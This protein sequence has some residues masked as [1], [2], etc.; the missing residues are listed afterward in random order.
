VLTWPVLVGLVGLFVALRAAP[1]V[2][3]LVVTVAGM[4]LL[5][6]V[7]AVLIL[8]YST[9]LSGVGFL[10]SVLAAAGAWRLSWG[11]KRTATPAQRRRVYRLHGGACGVLGCRR[12]GAQLD[13]VIPRRPPVLP[14]LL[15]GPSWSSNFRP[16]CGPA[17]QGGVA[18]NQRRGNRI[19][20][21]WVA[22]V[23]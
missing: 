22:G 16:L 9:S 11:P 19:T 5:R 20:R 8:V 23:R 18:H 6:I 21:G 4:I 13:H 14:W 2:L 17:A 10:V 1:I 7:P 12:A 15:G 3:G